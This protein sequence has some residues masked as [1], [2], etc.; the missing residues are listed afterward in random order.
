[1][2]SARIKTRQPAKK[3]RVNLANLGEVTRTAEKLLSFWGGKI[4]LP[5]KEVQKGIQEIDAYCQANINHPDIH[6][7]TKDFVTEG[8]RDESHLRLQANRLSWRFHYL[9][10]CTETPQGIA[11]T[12]LAIKIKGCGF[13]TKVITDFL[14]QCYSELPNLSL[15]EIKGLSEAFDQMKNPSQTLVDELLQTVLV[16]QIVKETRKIRAETEAI[17]VRTEATIARAEAERAQKEAAQKRIQELEKQLAAIKQQRNQTNTSEKNEGA[18][19]A[20]PFLP[21]ATMA[22]MSNPIPGDKRFDIGGQ[23]VVVK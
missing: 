15:D 3:F 21:S 23:K 13:D 5:S 14:H 16:S 22:T 12:D 4:T 2:F 19:N 8:K 10:N 11:V 9:K 1:M 17:I 20:K 6:F 7:N 18:G